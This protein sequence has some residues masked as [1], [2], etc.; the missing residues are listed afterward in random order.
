[1]GDLF[2][3]PPYTDDDVP[4]F[5][6]DDAPPLDDENPSREPA[7]KP[8]KT[9]KSAAV[10]S[11]PNETVKAVPKEPI[12]SVPNKNAKKKQA[13][14]APVQMREV[15]SEE[16]TAALAKL[17]DIDLSVWNM[18]QGSSVRTEGGRLAISSG[19]RMLIENVN[20]DELT[21]VEGLVSEALGFPVRIV[22]K[23]E[24]SENPEGELSEIDKFLNKAR[25]I[26]IDVTVKKQ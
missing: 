6:D 20:G 15:T 12:K 16:W 4:P 2:E 8:M 14:D 26:G 11:F 21:R 1:M 13:E 3:P 25:E 5:S 7:F 24:I 10:S 22:I 9:A 17:A 23:T 19:N 18:L